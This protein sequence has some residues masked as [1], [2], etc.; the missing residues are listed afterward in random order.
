M[1]CDCGGGTV[2]IIT[3]TIA[4]TSPALVFDEPC[5]G[6]G[7]STTMRLLCVRIVTNVT[8]REVWFHHYRPQL[9]SADAKEVWKSFR[10]PRAAASRSWEQVHECLGESKKIVRHGRHSL[11]ARIR[12]FAARR[13]VQL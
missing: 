3:Y 7:E 11:S 8:R 2:D 5:E 13:S 12:T 1:I 6:V 9:A 4:E 10:K